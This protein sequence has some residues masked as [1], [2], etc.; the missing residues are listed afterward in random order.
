V[1]AVAA[2]GVSGSRT[3]KPRCNERPGASLPDVDG[4]FAAFGSPRPNLFRRMSNIGLRKS[5][6][7]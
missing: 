2:S 1:V 7:R 6:K 4:G 3:A 5:G